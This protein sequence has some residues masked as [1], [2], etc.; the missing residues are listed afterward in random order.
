MR[1]SPSVVPIAT[2]GGRRAEHVEVERASGSPPG[3]RRRRRC[4]PACRTTRRGVCAFG[5]RHLEQ[6]A[7]RD[8][9]E[10]AVRQRREQRGLDRH[11][12]RAGHGELLHEAAVGLVEVGDLDPGAVVVGDEELAERGLGRGVG[13]RDARARSRPGRRS[14]V[15]KTSASSPTSVRA[16]DRRRRRR[17]GGGARRRRPCRTSRAGAGAPPL[18]TIEVLTA[19]SAAVPRRARAASRPRR[20]AGCRSG[21]RRRRSR[22]SARREAPGA[23]QAKRAHASSAT[24]RKGMRGENVIE[25][26]IRPIGQRLRRLAPRWTKDLRISTRRHPSLRRSAAPPRE[27][28]RVELD[29]YERRFRRAGLPLFIEDWNAS[30]GRLHPRGAAVRARVRRRGARRARQRLVGVG[31]PRRRRSAGWRSCSRASACSTWRAGAASSSCPH[32]VGR[33]ELAIFVIL[34]ALLPLVFSGQ[35][36][37][38]LVTA[39][40][41]LALLGARLPRDRLRPRVHPALGGAAAARAG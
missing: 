3:W 25:A 37:S 30:R 18:V 2:C 15:P 11:A 4:S 22:A 23:R 31:E 41:N 19:P 38:A 9:E 1:S 33:V 10:V 24:R 28:V 34:P 5:D 35:V 36:V 21:R 6:P 14:T 27:T 40:A 17:A 20:R 13:E 12:G 29:A 26:F 32:R 8:E 16:A 39:A 7:A